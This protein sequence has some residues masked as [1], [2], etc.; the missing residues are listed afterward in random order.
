M[1]I[2]IGRERERIYIYIYI[3][4]NREREIGGERD[5]YVIYIDMP[6]PHPIPTNPMTL[7]FRNSSGAILFTHT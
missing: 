4:I 1:Y 5:E 7:G 2:Y 6:T 3:N